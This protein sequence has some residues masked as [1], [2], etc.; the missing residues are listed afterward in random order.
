MR[1][2]IDL[3]R[4]K[5]SPNLNECIEEI[6]F[7]AMLIVGLIGCTL[8]VLLDLMVTKNLSYSIPANLATILVLLV[9]LYGIE[10]LK[11]HRAALYGLALLNIIITVRGFVNPE[12]HHVTCILLI[13]I[14]FMCALVSQ[15][16]WGKAIQWGILVSFIAILF[17]D[18]KDVAMIVLIRAAIPYLVV[19]FIITILSGLLKERYARNQNRLTELVA[20]LNQKNA[21]I[22]EQHSRLQ[23][24]YKELSDLN[25]YL[26]VS[27][28]QKTNRI[29]EKNKQLADISYENSHSLRAPLARILGLL[30]LIKIDPERKDFY[31][32]KLDDQ[33]LEMDSRICIVSKFIERNMNE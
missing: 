22:N 21:K 7:R 2:M 13:T 5:G 15:G 8:V 4:K 18:Y 20:L 27:I 17:K 9:C 32:S 3:L 1:R 28:K 16:S 19:Y 14:G 12:F 23:A 25:N 6:F 30:H 26:E 11:F 33:A 31:L 24:S 29:A 10:R